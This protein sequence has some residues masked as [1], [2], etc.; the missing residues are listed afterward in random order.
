M[1]KNSNNRIEEHE[2]R[3]ALLENAI[4]EIKSAV[5]DI[6][7]FMEK[8]IEMQYRLDGSIEQQKRFN[9]D[10]NDLKDRVTAE[11]EE[12]KKESLKLYKMLWRFGII[13]T[14]VAGAGSIIGSS[15]LTHY[16]DKILQ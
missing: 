7:N 2:T 1:Q 11:R 5:H 12:R 8:M 4:V 10:L 13:A 14:T 9:D 16:V 3:I 6:K 15:V